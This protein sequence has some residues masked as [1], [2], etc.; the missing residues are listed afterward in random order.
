MSHKV[1]EG[2]RSSVS[3]GCYSAFWGDSALAANQL[4]HMVTFSPLSL[5]SVSLSL[6]LSLFILFSLPLSISSLLST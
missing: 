1:K 2:L 4:I 6:S 5:L 3:I